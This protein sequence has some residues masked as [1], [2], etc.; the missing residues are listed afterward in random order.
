MRIERGATM[1]GQDRT[2][3][4]ELGR[5][6]QSSLRPRLVAAARRGDVS[7]SR[8]AALGR[9]LDDLFGSASASRRGATNE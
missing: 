2:G 9:L 8:A 6:Y 7:A 4:T 5:W 1:T 3:R